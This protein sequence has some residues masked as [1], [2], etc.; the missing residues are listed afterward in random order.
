MAISTFSVPID[1]PWQRIAFS[2]D[3][4]DKVA[5]DRELPLR[6]RSSVA[7]FEYEPP[8]EQQRQDGFKVSYLK[9][10][11]TITGYQPNDKEIRIRER[12]GKSGWTR[13][14]QNEELQAAVGAYYA[15]YGAMLEVV[16]APHPEERFTLR[17]YPYF[18]D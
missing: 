14:N 8:K 2:D 17:E 15:C 9:V 16:V 10:A 11:C 1:I 13:K 12:L 5:C 4:M 7:V 3:M 6:W 18:A